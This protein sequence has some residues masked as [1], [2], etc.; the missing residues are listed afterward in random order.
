M[1]FSKHH[2]SWRYH[3]LFQNTHR[4]MLPGF[5]YA[6]AIFTTYLVVE[7]FWPKPKHVHVQ[8]EDAG[9]RYGGAYEKE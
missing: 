5:G 7:R 6:V 2:E 9:P 1:V 3:P 8:I 4:A